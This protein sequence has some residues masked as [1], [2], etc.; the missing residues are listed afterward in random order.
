MIKLVKTNSSHKDFIG[1]VE[2]LD[3]YLKVTDGDEHEFYNQFNSLE[4]LKNV[5][6]AYQDNKPVGCGAFKEYN[7]DT[8]EIKRMYTLSEARGLSIASKILKILED[9]SKELEYKTSILETGNRQLEAIQFYKKNH[10]KICPNYGQYTNVENSVCF[11]K[12]LL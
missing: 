7:C 5:V 4:S 6:I 1:L 11:T 12:P 3:S 8:I 2:L 10:Y 9:W